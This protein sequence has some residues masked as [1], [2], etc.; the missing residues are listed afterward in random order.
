MEDGRWSVARFSR[1]GQSRKVLSIGSVQI[2]LLRGQGAR[3]AP[4][5][6][7]LVAKLTCGGLARLFVTN[8]DK[9]FDSSDA[10]ILNFYLCLPQKSIAIPLAF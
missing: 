8:K 3:N 7:R 9:N 6:I 1:G 5:V 10:T 4:F 2:A